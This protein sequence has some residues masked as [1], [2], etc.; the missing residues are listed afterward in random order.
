MLNAGISKAAQIRT[1]F[2]ANARLPNEGHQIGKILGVRKVLPNQYFVSRYPQIHY[3]MLYISVRVSDQ[4]YCAEYETPV[5]DEIDDVP[6]AN[7]ED[8]EVLLKDKRII[9]RTP[10]G[11]KLKARLVEAKQC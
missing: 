3:Y 9:L 6:S 5:L 11:R 8:V 2:S 1:Q 7:G 10:K 4:A